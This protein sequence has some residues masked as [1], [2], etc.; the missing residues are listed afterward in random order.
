MLASGAHQNYFAAMAQ[1]QQHQ[2]ALAHYVAAGGG[3]G[4]VGADLGGAYGYDGLGGMQIQSPGAGGYAGIPL[5]QMPAGGVFM[6]SGPQPPRGANRFSVPS[7]LQG[8]AA[9]HAAL[10]GQ[11]AQA[12]LMYPT[13]AA[14]NAAQG[15]G[16]GGGYL[17][18]G[19]PGSL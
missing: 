15:I 11:Q 18:P 12:Q 17:Q 7:F 10:L 3:G 1:Q 9:A 16:G 19:G 6:P 14:M 5:I 8:D 4:E 13:L 2:L